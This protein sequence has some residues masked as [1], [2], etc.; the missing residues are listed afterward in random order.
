MTI[1]IDWDV[2]PQTNQNKQVSLGDFCFYLHMQATKAWA[3]LHCLHTQSCEIDEGSCQN[4][5]C[6]AHLIAGYALSR[7]AYTG[8]ISSKS[9]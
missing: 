2:K 4:L 7:M 9:L 8:G 1:A 3:R 5:Y 6:I